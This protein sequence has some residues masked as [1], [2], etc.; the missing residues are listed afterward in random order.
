[1]YLYKVFFSVSLILVYYLVGSRLKCKEV[2][3]GRSKGEREE[4]T[5][6]SLSNF[7]VVVL[8]PLPAFPFISDSSCLGF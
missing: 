6:T 1:M 7:F 3:A 2:G 5:D 4:R 8:F